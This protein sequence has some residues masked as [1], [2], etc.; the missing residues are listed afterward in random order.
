MNGF[1]RLLFLSIALAAVS[2]NDRFTSVTLADAPVVPGTGTWIPFVGDDFEDTSWGFTHNHPKSS[3]ENDEQT[4][5]PRGWS[6]NG[7]FF[8]GPERGQPDSME[9]VPLHGQGLP[10]SEHGL[11]VRT[12]NSGIPGRHSYKVEQDDLIVD[13]VTRL[14]GPIP[15]SEVP[16]VVARI[17][18][19]PAEA[20]ENRYGPHFGFR[21][22][23]TTTV[24]KTNPA[25]GR[26]RFRSRSTTTT[27]LEPYWPG[28]WVHFRP[29]ATSDGG[30][31]Q[32]AFIKVRGNRLGHDFLVK[33]IPELGTWWT[34][35][36]SFTGDGMVHY[37]AKQG[38]EDLTEQDYLTSQYPYGFRAQKFETFFFNFCNKDDGKTWSTPIVIDDPQLFLVHANRVNSIVRNKEAAIERQA[39][40]RAR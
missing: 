4:R 5:F 26:G 17:Y 6:T 12:L 7:R 32:T 34:L 8:E 22:T 18:L 38:V 13:C 37:Y 29:Q 2:C 40:M 39:Q 11:L 28:M 20:W 16:N 9:V 25:S 15:V 31:A 33:E 27:E 3:R 10:G 19:P 23:T 35:G 1:T 24:T 30:A 21:G 14:G 36:M